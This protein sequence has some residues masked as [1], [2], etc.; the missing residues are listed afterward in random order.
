MRLYAI[1]VVFIINFINLSW[2]AY[3]YNSTQ[4]ELAR[5]LDETGFGISEIGTCKWF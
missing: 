5:K 4:C 2:S 3:D 1:T